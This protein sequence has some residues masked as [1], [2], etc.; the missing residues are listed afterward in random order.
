MVCGVLKE[1]LEHFASNIAGL[2]L[3]VA[4]GLLLVQSVGFLELRFEII[5][6]RSVA[7]ERSAFLICCF[8]NLLFEE[9]RAP[10]ILDARECSWHFLDY[11][12]VS[13]VGFALACNLL[14][15][16]LRGVIRF[17]S[18]FPVDRAVDASEMEVGKWFNIVFPESL[19]LYVLIFISLSQIDIFEGYLNFIVERSEE[20]WLFWAPVL[21]SRQPPDASR[22]RC[23]LR[24]L[25]AP[26]V[27]LAELDR[28]QPLCGGTRTIPRRSRPYMRHVKDSTDS[29]GE[30]R[31]SGYSG[32]Y[33]VCSSSRF[34]SIA[35]SE[36]S[37]LKDSVV[38]FWS[39]FWVLWIEHRRLQ[40]ASCI[41]RIRIV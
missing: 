40:Y 23:L 29:Q 27:C 35:C 5:L 12:R 41:K 37:S 19:Q 9:T 28:A 39:N 6:V 14:K 38:L 21:S 34:F 31:S 13:A 3:V 2:E 16:P 24:V 1:F 26:T 8:G 11:E 18:S 17:G 15:G 22:T 33:H 32:M 7:G 20:V 25:A 30:A 10:V 4:T 36:E